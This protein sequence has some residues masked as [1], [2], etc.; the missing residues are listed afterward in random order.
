MVFFSKKA[1]EAKPGHNRWLIP[2]AALAIHLCIGQVYAF[3]VFRLPMTRLLGITGP[4]PG[5]WEKNQVFWA[6][7][8]AI[9]FLGL[10]AAVF[11]RW[12]ERVGP[13]VSG[14]VSALLWS[15]GFGVAA[16]GVWLHQLWLLCL[17]YGVIGGCGLGI[18][19]ITPVS[20]L[21]KWFPD[22][23]GLAT[24]LAIMGFG[25][26][27]M[28][29]SPLSERLLAWFAGPDSTGVVGALLVLGA[30]Y[31]PVMLAGAF[32]FRLPPTETVVEANI[33]SAG[34]AIGIGEAVDASRAI[35]TRSF[36]CLWLVLFCNVTAGIGILDVASPMIQEIFPGRLN[37][38]LAAGFVGLLSLFNL[39]GR[40]GWSSASDRLGR[41]RAYAIYLSL[42]MLLYLLE[43]WV[44][45]Q[46]MLPLFV[47]LMAVIMS[48]YGGV[49]ATI[50]AYLSDVFGTGH[51]G[52]IHGRL[53][54][55]WSCAGVAG[56]YL[57]NG[58]CKM[59]LERG[60]PPER[61]YDLALWM[62]SALLVVGLVANAF[63]KK[64]VADLPRVVIPLSWDKKHRV[65]SPSIKNGS[66]Q[67]F[68]AWSLVLLPMGWGIWMTLWKASSLLALR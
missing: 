43:P 13:R 52:S 16:L 47:L 62:V 28:V 33:H 61:A 32:A 27:A 19:Y 59:Q 57:V 66:I 24:G 39:A 2:P 4:L 65:W 60:I 48:F 58:V 56:P 7:S 41:Q 25:G 44:A 22:K 67:L 35:W 9:V 30:V 45:R 37:A 21:I 8:L 3:S 11:G 34:R 50:P 49:F 18:G 36:A 6:F 54:T 46:G 20:T 15:G 64:R 10:S 63:V 53:L 17:G 42:G 1:I 12:V 5:D 40:L 51:V 31:L 55:A 68:L 26:G 14:T 38:S 23:R 29:A